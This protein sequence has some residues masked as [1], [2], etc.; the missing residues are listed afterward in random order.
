M[1]DF[2]SL[3]L[4]AHHISALFSVIGHFH[5]WFESIP[6]IFCSRIDLICFMQLLHAVLY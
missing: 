1:F 3:Q 6:V 4:L 5:H 2:D